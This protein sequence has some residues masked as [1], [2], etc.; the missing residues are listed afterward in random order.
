MSDVVQE[1]VHQLVAG[2][3]GQE[4]DPP[5]LAA[6]HRLAGYS[7]ITPDIV[8]LP[9]RS[10]SS[11]DEV[12]RCPGARPAP[13]PAHPSSSPDSPVPDSARSPGSLHR[14]NVN[15]LLTKGGI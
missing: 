14:S 8:L 4:L 2:L 9:G 11:Q 13:P 7:I 12:S 3:A 10:V 15:G 1:D 5:L 6:F